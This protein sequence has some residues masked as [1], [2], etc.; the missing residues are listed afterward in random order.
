MLKIR[1]NI[2]VKM[3][4]C[5]AIEQARPQIQSQPRKLETRAR[6]GLFIFIYFLEEILGWALRKEDKAQ[7]DAH[8]I[9]VF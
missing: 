9:F 6:P 4:A 5:S 2:S 3:V 1:N 7:T 8:N